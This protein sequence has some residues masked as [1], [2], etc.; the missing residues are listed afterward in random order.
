[1]HAAIG[2]PPAWFA[3]VLA[4]REVR[5]MWRDG[6]LAPGDPELEQA[7]IDVHQRG[8]SK[9]C[10]QGWANGVVE[11]QQQV[12]PL[13]DGFRFLAVRIDVARWQLGRRR[14]GIRPEDEEFGAQ[15]VPLHP[16]AEL[17]Q[18]RGISIGP[19]RGSKAFQPIYVATELT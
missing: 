2:S 16:L 8:A 4:N 12:R 3:H 19:A 13:E 15:T 18:R 7:R 11:V 9:T 17:G 10:E 1:M 5:V 14:L 6:Q